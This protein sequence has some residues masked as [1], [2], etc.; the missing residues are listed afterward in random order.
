[1]ANSSYALTNVGN[2]SQWWDMAMIMCICLTP[3]FGNITSPTKSNIVSNIYYH[4][5]ITRK[6]SMV[7]IFR[8]M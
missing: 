3:Q 6:L 8:K 1:M 4:A 5:N 7:L 2:Y